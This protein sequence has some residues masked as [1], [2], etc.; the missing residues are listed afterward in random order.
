MGAQW[1]ALVDLSHGL[2]ILPLVFRKEADKSQRRVGCE[3]AQSSALGDHLLISPFAS[4]CCSLAAADRHSWLPG[5]SGHGGLS[6]FSQCLPLYSSGMALYYNG[7]L[8]SSYKSFA[9]RA[10]KR[11][12]EADAIKRAARLSFP[13]RQPSPKIKITSSWSIHL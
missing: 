4:P 9:F 11:H 12:G 13:S 1:H 3:Q 6:S 5:P 2:G 8:Q 10:K 7:I